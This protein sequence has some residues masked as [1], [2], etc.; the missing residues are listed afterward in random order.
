M[1]NELRVPGQLNS[2][3]GICLFSEPIF[4]KRQ[5]NFSSINVLLRSIIVVFGVWKK[6]RK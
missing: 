3:R 4:A 2:A 5:V 1:Y 6:N